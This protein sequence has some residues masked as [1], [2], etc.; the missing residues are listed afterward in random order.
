MAIE[1][2]QLLQ[3]VRLDLDA[4]E[5]FV[6]KR[7]GREAGLLS[8]VEGVPVLPGLLPQNVSARSKSSPM[9]WDMLFH[10]RVP[11]PIL[12]ISLANW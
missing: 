11:L 1:P 12:F 6:G 3:L 4:T 5:G 9:I 7:Q 10:K 2:A 8:E